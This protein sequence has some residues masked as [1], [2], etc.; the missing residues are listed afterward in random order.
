MGSK[1]RVAIAGVGNCASSLVQGVE[2]YRGAANQENVPGVMHASLGGYGIGDIEF[3]AAFDVNAKKVGRPLGEAILAEP[4]NTFRFAAE[5][6]SEI[7][8]NRGPTLDGMGKYVREI[9]EES[10]APPVDV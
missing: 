1:I 5:A 6:T 3:S 4:N 8:V 7:V 10:S 2:H 9:V